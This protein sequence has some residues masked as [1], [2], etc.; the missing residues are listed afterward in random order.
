MV[1]AGE[2][3]KKMIEEIKE[4]ALSTGE[5]TREQYAA[6]DDVIIKMQEEGRINNPAEFLENLK[7][8]AAEAIDIL[9]EYSDLITT[10]TLERLEDNVW[11]K[12]QAVRDAEDKL[13]DAPESEKKEAQAALHEA[14]RALAEAKSL[15]NDFKKSLDRQDELLRRQHKLSVLQMRLERTNNE[16]ILDTV[17]ERKNIL[18]EMERLY[19]TQ[20]EE[21]YDKQS[22]L[23]GIPQEKLK[24]YVEM[25][26]TGKEM[27]DV[28]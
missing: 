27:E 5:F 26:K 10:K 4:A 16:N 14:K 12:E 25:V 28:E 8:G 23:I 2:S 19:N 24:A 21:E 9:N 17:K 22:R 20:L 6:L 13:R 11:T 7:E 3:S 18:E 1:T 15:W